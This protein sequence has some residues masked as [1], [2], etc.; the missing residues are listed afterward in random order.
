MS[1]AAKSM[2]RRSTAIHKSAVFPAT[3]RIDWV[4]VYQP[5]NAINVGCDTTDYPTAAYIQ[6]YAEAYNNPNLTTW[7]GD[8]GQPMPKNSFL[9]QC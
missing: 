5:K 3:M 2:Y 1:G 8:Y 7:T 4:R 6:Q 9:G